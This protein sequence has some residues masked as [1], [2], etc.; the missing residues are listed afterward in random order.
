M[1]VDSEEEWF[2]TKPYG[3][4]GRDHVEPEDP[5]QGL[6]S[7]L[8]WQAAWHTAV[9][10]AWSDS[11]HL[12]ELIRDPRAFFEDRCGY[13]LPEGLTLRIVETPPAEV[14]TEPA[15]GWDPDKKAWRLRKTVVTMYLPPAPALEERAVA[16][17]AF[18]ATG[19][20]YPFSVC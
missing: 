8:L 4:A 10:L 17:A 18:A 20:A 11:N 2:E 6:R 19:R 1:S 12:S 14:P 13:V 5:I 16:L 7:T 15:P 9:A 3:P